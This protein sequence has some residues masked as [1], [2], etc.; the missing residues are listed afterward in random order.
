M[1]ANTT[2]TLNKFRKI[3]HHKAPLTFLR[4]FSTSVH[5]DGIDK[6]SFSNEHSDRA[7]YEFIGLFHQKL[8]YEQI[9]SGLSTLPEDVKQLVDKQKRLEEE[10]RNEATVQK[11]KIIDDLKNLKKVTQTGSVKSIY[12]RWY[13]PFI[14]SIRKE[15]D[16]IENNMH[17]VDRSVS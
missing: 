2:N 6:K 4:S 16:E 14:A 17:A 9:P 8:Q 12:L 7:F 5:N 15:R 13:D 1:L 11:K 10:Q 3:V